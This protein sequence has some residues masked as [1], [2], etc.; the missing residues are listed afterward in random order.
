MFCFR[1]K[2]DEFFKLFAESTHLF[3]EGAYILH[4]V[5]SDYT[6]IGEK[7]PQI[8]NLEHEA[9]DINDDII[10]KLNRTFI[11]P[12]DREDIYSLANMLDDGV[13]L[14]QGILERMML[15]RTGQPSEGAVQLS[16]LVTL[17][18]EEL[19]HAFDLLRNIR[20]NQEKILEHTRKIVSLE[21]EGDRIYRQEV[22]HLFTSCGD[23]LEVIKWKEVL[24]NLEDTLD[25]CESIAD[26]LR[27]VI[28]KYA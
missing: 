13:D 6:K 24:E 22:A 2:E 9:D 12:L 17:C 10:D 21:S 19:L 8:A 25:H 26:L 18:A 16:N 23:P 11:T 1:S 3:R 5:M 7:I 27:G 28:M 4:E 15:Y 14:I 20:G